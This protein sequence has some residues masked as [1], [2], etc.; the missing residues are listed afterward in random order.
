MTPCFFVI[1]HGIYTPFCGVEN[2]LQLVVELLAPLVR[3]L[4][5]AVAASL[6]VH[7]LRTQHQSSHQQTELPSGFWR[8]LATAL[9]SFDLCEFFFE[10][11]CDVLAQKVVEELLPTDG[12][13]MFFSDFF[14]SLI[15]SFFAEI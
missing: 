2:T 15:S 13:S 10:F 12:S 1:S 11:F 8:L 9:G 5:A 7:A 6:F 14:L 3:S 4:V